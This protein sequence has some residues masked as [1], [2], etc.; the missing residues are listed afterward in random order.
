MSRGRRLPCGIVVKVKHQEKLPLTVQVQAR[1]YG[2]APSQKD[3]L[4]QVFST[5]SVRDP[6]YQDPATINQESR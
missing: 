1:D 2:V 4:S 3:D 5:G 6:Q